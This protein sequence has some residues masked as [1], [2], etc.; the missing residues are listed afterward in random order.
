MVKPQSTPNSTPNGTE[1]LLSILNSEYAEAFIQPLHGLYCSDS[2]ISGLIIHR[3]H[4]ETEWNSLWEQRSSPSS[5]RLTRL[6]RMF[7]KAKLKEKFDQKMELEKLVHE[8][9]EEPKKQ[10]IQN[11]ITRLTEEL[12][13]IPCIF[14][15]SLHSVKRYAKLI[16]DEIDRIRTTVDAQMTALTRPYMEYFITR[17]QEII[18]QLKPKLTI[19]I[20]SIINKL[21]LIDIEKKYT[22]K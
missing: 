16:S 1:L 19:E 20:N 11:D 4:I 10:G 8:I 15:K 9:T 18:D 7:D 5:P 22:K 14:P 17:K 13:G 3:V 6:E 12:H 21:I 2:M